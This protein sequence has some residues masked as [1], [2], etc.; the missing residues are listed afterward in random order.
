MKTEIARSERQFEN[1]EFCHKV[2]GDVFVFRML[3]DSGQTMC[4]FLRCT[5]CLSAL[6]MSVVALLPILLAATPLLDIL[7]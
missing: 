7:Y 5:T 1:C 2:K 3:N 6:V 4:S